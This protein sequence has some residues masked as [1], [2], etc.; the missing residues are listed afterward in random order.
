MGKK[1]IW[2]QSKH[3]WGASAPLFFMKVESDLLGNVTIQFNIQGEAILSPDQ[4]LQLLPCDGCKKLDW[5]EL[6]VI[7]FYCPTCFEELLR[8]NAGMILESNIDYRAKYEAAC[9]Y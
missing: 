7:S 2:K 1:S 9:G 4:K 3:K 5:K 8:Q 6:N